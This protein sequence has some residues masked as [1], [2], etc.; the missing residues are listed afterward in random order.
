MEEAGLNPAMM[1]GMSGGGGTTVGNPS[2]SVSGGT[3]STESQLRANE[4]AQQGM[5]LQ[6][7]KLHGIVKLVVVLAPM[8]G[9]FSQQFLGRFGKTIKYCTVRHTLES[10]NA[11][12][13]Y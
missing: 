10:I 9:V 7:A 4:V 2:G 5:G 11:K 8:Y 12:I 1:Y 13:M 3:A 6:L